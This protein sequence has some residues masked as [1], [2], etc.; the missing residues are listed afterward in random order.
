[1]GA[2]AKLAESQKREDQ[3]RRL[4][5][6]SKEEVDQ[7]TT[8]INVIQRKYMAA[9]DDSRSW[10]QKYYQA[11]AEAITNANNLD[12]RNKE[13][14]ELKKKVSSLEAQLSQPALDSRNV[15]LAMEQEL[16]DDKVKIHQLENKLS[17]A[18]NEREY[19]KSAYQDA[20]RMLGESQ[21][22]NHAL[23]QE[24]KEFRRKADDNIVKVNQIH[25]E[26]ES[27][28][29]VRMLDEQK[30]IVRERETELSRLRDLRENRRGTRQS[31]VP[32]SPRLSAFG[33]NSPRNGGRGIGGS[34]SRGT[35]PA[36]A[37][38]V[39]EAGPGGG[40]P[41]PNNRTSHLRESRY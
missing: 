15:I 31:S 23:A 28:E 6:R 39:F 36:P 5:D 24:N 3:F 14:E 21:V 1:M 30:A 17:I 7:Y 37:S 18:D 2:E 27:K 25:A 20:S 9:L 32:R 22:Q 38:G 29:L 33:V 35:S 34:S 4:A 8:S 41:A 11:Q 40:T 16:K 13:V 10:E 19:A 12:S 26:N